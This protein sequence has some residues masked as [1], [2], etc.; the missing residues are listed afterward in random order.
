MGVEVDCTRYDIGDIDYLWYFY[1]IKINR[2]A[3]HFVKKELLDDV[4]FTCEFKNGQEWY[5]WFHLGRKTKMFVID[6]FISKKEY[7]KNPHDI[8]LQHII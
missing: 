1:R 4:R 2:D 3:H 6:K 5:F 8:N 7:L